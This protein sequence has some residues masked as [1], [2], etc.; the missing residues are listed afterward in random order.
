MN[1]LDRADTADQALATFTRAT[2]M[3]GEDYETRISDLVANLIHLCD[4][5][6]VV[7]DDVITRAK[8]HHEFELEDES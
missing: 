6:D 1:N 2:G 5:E 7:I 4:R 8:Q 3:Q